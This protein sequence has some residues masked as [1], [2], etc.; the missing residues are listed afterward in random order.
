MI[1]NLA[2]K[3]NEVF[4]VECQAKGSLLQELTSIIHQ[5][6][7]VG[8]SK[9]PGQE[10]SQTDMIILMT[11]AQSMAPETK[12]IKISEL[13]AKLDVTPANMTHAIDPLVKKGYVERLDDPKDRRLVLIRPTEKGIE[14][15]V[16]LRDAFMKKCEGLMKF[17]GEDDT[18]EMVRLMNLA[19]NYFKKVDSKEPS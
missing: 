16:S 10:I 6:K 2:T 1:N 17:L 18:R 3:L 13:S 9:T 8:M 12:G 7:K 5:F 15:V 14:A 4:K 19:L 11:L